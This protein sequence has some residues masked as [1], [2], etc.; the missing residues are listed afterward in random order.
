MT[1]TFLVGIIAF[2]PK[3]NPNNEN[4]QSCPGIGGQNNQPVQIYVYPSPSYIRESGIQESL[5]IFL[6]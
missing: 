2:T 5:S 1:M 3:E 6:T 4:D